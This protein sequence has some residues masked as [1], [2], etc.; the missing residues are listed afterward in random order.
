VLSI[1]VLVA[2][3]TRVYDFHYHLWWGSIAHG[4]GGI[5]FAIVASQM[6]FW[7]LWSFIVVSAVSLV[8]S[9]IGHCPL[10]YQPLRA[11]GC[12]GLRPLGFLIMLIW[13]YA[14]SVAGCIY[15]LF[16]RGY[17]RLEVNP[18]IWVIGL[19]A[20][21]CLPLIAILPLLS[22]T[23]AIKRARHHYLRSIEALAHARRSPATLAEAEEL[24]KLLDLRK[25]VA[26]GNVFPFG[27][28]TIAA[29]SCLS[30]LQDAASVSELL[31]K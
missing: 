30:L 15:V 14:I 11:D 1:L 22:V 16:S 10:T 5:A 19:T 25:A 9:Q 13:C 3:V 4:Y 24:H 12:N 21:I 17:L 27:P 23:A 8:L 31:S 7:G 28:Q 18:V 20:S 26:Q 29:F 2:L 6:V